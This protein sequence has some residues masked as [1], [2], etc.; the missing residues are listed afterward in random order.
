[1]IQNIYAISYHKTW[2]KGM[3]L[4]GFYLYRLFFKEVLISPFNKNKV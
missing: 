1:M 3:N 2:I 4:Q